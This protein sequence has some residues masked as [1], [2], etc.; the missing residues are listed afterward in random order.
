M[1]VYILS[2]EAEMDLDEIAAYIA[3]DNTDAALALLLKFDTRFAL[4]ADHPKSGRERR[5]L[6]PALRSTV[7]GRY[8]IFY[9]EIPGGVE[10]ARVLH[11]ARDVERL[12]H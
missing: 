3:A 10:I 2:E 7:E 4:L 5:E 9:R 12:F 6:A 11:S 1:S 8:V